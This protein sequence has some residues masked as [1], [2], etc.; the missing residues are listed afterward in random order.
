MTHQRSPYGL[1][2]KII[3]QRNNKIY[4]GQ[5]T[6]F[7]NFYS[8]RYYCGSKYVKNARNKYGKDF[9]KREI[10]GF[11]Y[12]QD[13]LD[14]AESACIEFFQSTD[15][16]YGYNI[17]P[18][19]ASTK[20]PGGYKLSEEAR[21]NISKAQIGH[22]RMSDAGKARIRLSNSTRS[23][24]KQTCEK[25]SQ[26]N[27]GKVWDDDRKK[28]FAEF[29]TGKTQSLETIEKIRFSNI[30]KHTGKRGKQKNPCIC[31]RKSRKFT[32]EM[33]INFSIGQQKRYNEQRFKRI[34]EVFLYFDIFYGTKILIKQYN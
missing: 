16:I 29:R 20:N 28:R 32:D 34:I 30:G 19:P 22:K 11:C 13:E 3:D 23:V 1:I 21:L 25:I 6:K 18:G 7:K 14:S 10:L 15:K 8:E 9:F 12:S 5:T 31:E 26:S 4:I 17:I 33:R 2:Y 27:K 24:S